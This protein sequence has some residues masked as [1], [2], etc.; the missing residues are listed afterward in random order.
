MVFLSPQSDASRSGPAALA[1]PY[2][3][4]LFDALAFCLLAGLVVVITRG[5]AQF[6]RPL[7]ALQ[8][9]PVQLDILRLP[10]YAALTTLRM[11]AALLASLIFTFIV[12]PLA[13]KSRKAG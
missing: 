13:A 5:G 7:S 2:L 8:A 10:G 12:A 9:S 11:F 4:N 6:D 3:P 1:R